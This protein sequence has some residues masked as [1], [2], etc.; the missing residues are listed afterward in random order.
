MHITLYKV[1]DAKNV[2]DKTLDNTTALKLVGT[3]RDKSDV[4]SPYILIQSNPMDY[5]YAYIQ[6]FNRY[7]FIEDI[8]SVRKNAWILNLSV[9]VLMSYNT[10]IKLMHGIVSRLTDGSEYA[11]RNIVAE[12]KETCRRIDF[13]Y[14]FTKN[15]TYVLIGK[16]D[17]NSGS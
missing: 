11:P 7:Y 13:D 10:E 2:L 15:G 3:L 14:S 12:D 8:V 16:G 4:V 1:S 17:V 9:D 5:N 6:E